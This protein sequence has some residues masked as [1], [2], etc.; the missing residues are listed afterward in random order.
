MAVNIPQTY[1]YIREERLGDLNSVAYILRHKKSKARIFLLS[2]DDENKVFTIGF[3]TPPQ[4]STGVAHILEHSVLCGSRKFPIKDPFVELVKGS[5]NTFLNAM[6]YPDKTVYPVASCNDADFQNLMDVYMDAVFHPRI[7]D[8]DKIFK[9][10]GWHYEL[11]SEDAPLTINGV[12]YNEMKGAFSTAESVL[13]RQIQ[14]ALYPDN[15]YGQESGGDPAVIPELSYEEFLAFHKKY[16]HPSN[17]YI[18]LYGDMDM[19][20]KLCWLDE[21]YLSEFEAAEVDSRIAIQKPFESPREKTLTYAA[22]EGEDNG[23]YLAMAASAGTVLDSRQYVAMGILDYALLDAP[24]APLKQALLDRK[25]CKDVYGGTETSILQPYFSVVAKHADPSRMAEFMETIQT[26][27]SELSQKG[28]NRRTLSAGLNSAEF[29]CREADFGHYPKG[30]MYGLQCF[31]SWLYEETDPLMHLKFGETFQWLRDHMEEGYFEDLIQRCLLDN[32][33][34]VQIVMNPEKGLAAKEEEALAKKLAQKKA[35]LSREE[36]L[37][38]VKQTR[39]LK[40]YQEEADT[41]EAL[42]KIPMLSRADIG[43]DPAP[44]Y[45]RLKQETG[46]QVLHHELFTGGIGYIRILFD[47]DG[48]TDEELQYAALLR[49]LLRMVNTAHYTYGELSDEIG[50][51]CGG[52]GAGFGSYENTT[53]CNRFLGVFELSAKVMTSKLDFVFRMFEEIVFTSDLTDKKR[54]GEIIAQSSSRQQ[55]RSI[56][57]GHMTAVG[58]AAAFVGR[59]SRFSEE[60]SGVEY[61]RFLNRLDASFEEMGDEVVEKLQA[62]RDKIFKPS[63][64]FVSYTSDEEGYRPLPKLLEHFAAALAEHFQDDKKPSSEFGAEKAGYQLTN[65]FAAKEG[66]TTSAQV[67]YVARVGNFASHGLRY[68][69]RLRIL[70]VILNYDYLWINLRVKGGAYG[71]MSG[72]SR[73]GESYLV[74]YRD[75]HLAKTNEIYEGIPAYLRSFQA[76]ERDMT[77]YIIGTISDMDVPQTPQMKGNRS[78]SAYLCGLSYE[79]LQ[80][81]RKELLSSQPE[82]IR[83]LADHVEAILETGV[84]CVVGGET[85][86]REHEQLFDVVEDL[87]PA[88]SR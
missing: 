38:L 64:M 33:H 17:S 42:A 2:N 12:V 83:A 80:A 68:T 14:N 84:F 40:A 36:I 55:M 85:K 9:Q 74:S 28:L 13:E 10:E 58:R 3:R 22:K 25:L 8:I 50:I 34:Q 56:S 52:L 72:F 20:E 78:L 61:I 87:F 21:A 73:S 53:D 66:L 37:D 24:G 1:E 88:S 51:H 39:E 79:K 76:D 15:T 7:Y 48:L 54:I 67:Q 47:V 60:I 32:P 71:C 23:S 26:V 6:T 30:L 16:Y 63:R 41:P 29:K 31:D 57:S 19:E 46:G 27:L 75:P 70:S 49:S 4:N 77:K 62:V 82:D 65:G 11:E 45:N 43:K 44:F 35:S 81:D 59:A 69:S 18:Y 5:L 86:I